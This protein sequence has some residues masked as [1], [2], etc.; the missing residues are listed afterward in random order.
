M[1]NKQDTF[2]LEEEQKTIVLSSNTENDLVKKVLKTLDFDLE[3]HQSEP[4]TTLFTLGKLKSK[5]VI[6]INH[7]LEDWTKALKTI[8]TLKEDVLL[9][10]DTFDEEK[11]TGLFEG[12]LTSGYTFNK[13]KTKDPQDKYLRSYT[14][15]NDYSEVIHKGI[16][17]GEAINH[18]KDL[19]N[20]PYNYMN[21]SDLADYASSLDVIDRVKVRVLNK[22]DIEAL[23][24]GAF[25]G[26]NK[27]SL[28]EPKL[29]HLEYT[30]DSSNT[31][32]TALIGKGVMYDTGGYSLKTPQSMPSMKC[33]MAGAATVLG[34]FEA[35]SRLKLKQN[36]SVVIAATD[37]RIGDEAIVPDDIVTAANGLTIEII[38]TDAEGRLTL[39]DALWY[40]QKKGATKMID[41]ATLTGAVVAAL[42]KEFTGAFTNN[43]TFLNELVE[44][45]KET[46]ES[47]WE[48]PI[49]KGYKDELKSY[50]ADLKNKGGRLAGAS[51]AAAFLEYFVENDTPWIHLDIAG[52]SFD[53]TNGA[54]GIM[55]KTLVKYFE[56]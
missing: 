1:F 13:F 32:L 33:D 14:S 35:I 53:S 23:N 52:T 50:V 7:Q 37:N 17:L 49:S 44:V 6:F 18:T 8:S 47:L 43:K 22:K 3:N 36:V 46:K 38:S 20:T 30:G 24:M 42:G 40:A 27:G 11:I 21:A 51:V 39:A 25:L 48:L 16:V 54:T 56:Q 12:L 28:H 5:K 29:I 15:T 10:L 4:F 2:V 26:V 19:V 9:L 45:S 34:A 31:E 55:V 41:L